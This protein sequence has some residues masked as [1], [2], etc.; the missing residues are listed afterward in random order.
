MMRLP[1]F[2]CRV[3]IVCS[4]FLVS[5]SFGQDAAPAAPAAPAETPAAPGAPAA[6]APAT[7]KS[8]LK[9]S[10]EN[11]WHYGKIARYDMAVAAAQEI[12]TAK[13]QPEAVLVAFEQTAQE[14][15]D[16]IDEWLIR[17]QGVEQM[18]EPANQITAILNEGRR[19]RRSNPQHIEENIKR[20]NRPGRPYQ[21]AVTQLR[22]S[23]ELA[24]PIM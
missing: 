8:D 5:S 13:D 18:R 6:A 16:S 7:Q 22:Q 20:L 1:R 21:I 3:V 19:A 9:R 4:L 17:W 2:I 24:V 23:G 12:V 15:H 10:V 14:R 11:F